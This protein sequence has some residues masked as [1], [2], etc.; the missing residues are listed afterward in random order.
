[1]D[2][3]DRAV[4]LDPE[5]ATRE[6]AAD[7]ARRE[8]AIPLMHRLGVDDRIDP[9]AAAPEIRRDLGTASLV[10]DLVPAADQHQERRAGRPAVVEAGD[11]RAVKGDV[12]GKAQPFAIWK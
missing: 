5:R 12:P 7:Q 9:A 8:G 1:M 11:A 4:A 3:A 2:V 6:V 10:G